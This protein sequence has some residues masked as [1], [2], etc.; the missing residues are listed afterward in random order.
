MAAELKFW[1]GFSNTGVSTPFVAS[2][3][4]HD[5]A[6]ED[7][8]RLAAAMLRHRAIRR[9]WIGRLLLGDL[10][11]MAAGLWGVDEWLADSPWRFLAWWGTCAVITLLVILAALHDALSVIR[12]ERA[13]HR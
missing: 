8:K 9:R 4:K 6:W 5:D 12:E 1:V 2:P 13:G 3:E 10:L 11:F 7:S